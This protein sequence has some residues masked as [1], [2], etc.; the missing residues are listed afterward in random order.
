VTDPF[1]WHR[2]D[3]EAGLGKSVIISIFKQGGKDARVYKSSADGSVNVGSGRTGVTAFVRKRAMPYE[4][5][6]TFVSVTTLTYSSFVRI[7]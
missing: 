4:L 7:F 1:P 5:P 6:F 2:E 3:K